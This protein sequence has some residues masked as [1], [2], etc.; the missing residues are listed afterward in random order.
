MLYHILCFAFWKSCIF[1]NSKY[2]TQFYI[3]FLYFNPKNRLISVYLN[4]IK[5]V[6]VPCGPSGR[7][8]MVVRFTFTYAISASHH[9]SY[10]FESHSW[11][12]V[13]DTTLCDK[14]CQW[15]AAGRWFSL[16]TSVSSTNKTDCHHITEILL[17]VAFNTITLTPSSTLLL[18]GM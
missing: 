7:N 8:C 2:N 1:C 11:W 13:L 16:G 5:F 9:E 10:E 6:L 12:D 14:V 4:D 15:L 17:K 3:K 18:L